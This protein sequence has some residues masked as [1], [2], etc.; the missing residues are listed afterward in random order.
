[1][2][3]GIWLPDAITRQEDLVLSAT[4]ASGRKFLIL[5]QWGSDFYRTELVDIHPNGRQSRYIIDG[6][7]NKWIGFYSRAVIDE[8]SRRV[9]FY[10]G[11]QLR[12][13]YRWESGNWTHYYRL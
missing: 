12:F 11:P 2:L 10:R 7:D 9:D 5:Q 1:M 13:S 6:D 8:R 3:F 4:S